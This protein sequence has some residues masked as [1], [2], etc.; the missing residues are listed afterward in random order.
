MSQASGFRRVTEAL[1]DATG[2]SDEELRLALTLVALATVVVTSL[3]LVRWLGDLG[4]DVLDRH[5]G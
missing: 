3:R 4:T 1:A 2:R 5:H